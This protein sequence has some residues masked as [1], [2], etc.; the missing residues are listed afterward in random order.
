MFNRWMMPIVVALIGAILGGPIVGLLAGIL[1]ALVWPPLTKWWHTRR[2]LQ[3]VERQDK[4]LEEYDVCAVSPADYERFRLATWGETDPS[5]AF[6]MDRKTLRHAKLSY[7][8]YAKTAADRKAVVDK[9]EDRRRRLGLLTQEEARN[10]K[11]AWPYFK[12]HYEHLK[13]GI[14]VPSCWLCDQNTEEQDRSHLEIWGR[15]EREDAEEKAKNDSATALFCF[16][17]LPPANSIKCEEAEQFYTK[18]K[19]KYSELRA[20]CTD[21]K[22]RQPINEGY[23]LILGRINAARACG[24]YGP[25]TVHGP[26]P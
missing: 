10:Y 24:K 18:L 1:A 25:C 15:A 8:T 13:S 21:W 5:K 2:Y 12:P 22:D 9:E 20:A 19:L 6:L 26:K 3:A 7:P 16:N 17:E 11:V 23:S 4:F 14:K